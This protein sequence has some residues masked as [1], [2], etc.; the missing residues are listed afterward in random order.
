[1]HGPEEFPDQRL[2]GAGLL[3][4]DAIIEVKI[5]CHALMLLSRH[6]GGNRWGGGE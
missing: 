5:E 1:V 2:A 6:P 3:R 4:I